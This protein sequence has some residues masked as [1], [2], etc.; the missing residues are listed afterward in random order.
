MPV[1]YRTRIQ[2]QAVI[3]I[4]CSQWCKSVGLTSELLSAAAAVC[5]ERTAVVKCRGRT[6][7]SGR[8]FTG[9]LACRSACIA[10]LRGRRGEWGGAKGQGAPPSP[11]LLPTSPCVRLIKNCTNPAEGGRAGRGGGGEGHGAATRG[12]RNAQRRRP[13][14]RTPAQRPAPL[15]PPTRRGYTPAFP[16]GGGGGAARANVHLTLVGVP[17][18]GGESAG[19]ELGPVPSGTPV[20]RGALPL[21]GLRRLWCRP[22][23]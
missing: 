3:E 14:S 5:T 9:D 17:L 16:L 13:R 19:A 12:D 1:E 18:V 2:L 23:R 22:W 20:R 4:R 6:I 21:P 11:R 15:V 7:Y 10:L 8:Q